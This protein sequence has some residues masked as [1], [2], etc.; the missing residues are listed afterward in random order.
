ME[1]LNV[2]IDT[3]SGSKSRLRKEKDT[4]KKGKEVATKA[5]NDDADKI[6][7]SNNFLTRNAPVFPN[8]D[9]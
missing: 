6:E 7:N 5:E 4:K 8:N 2:A 3:V 1:A 9:L